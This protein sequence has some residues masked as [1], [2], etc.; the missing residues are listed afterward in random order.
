MRNTSVSNVY[1]IQL[2]RCSQSFLFFSRKIADIWKSISYSMKSFVSLCPKTTSRMRSQSNY[3]NEKLN[4][5]QWTLKTYYGA[6]LE[7]WSQYTALRLQL[8]RG[9]TPVRV[10]FFLTNFVHCN[11]NAAS[12]DPDSSWKL[13][14]TQRTC[15]VGLENSIE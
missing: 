14:T 8:Q 3:I 7:H 1:T 11:F 12:D 13:F 10:L 4:I 15:A 5:N 6:R 9:G 2:Y